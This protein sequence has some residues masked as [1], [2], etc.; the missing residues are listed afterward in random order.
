LQ[1]AL[2]CRNKETTKNMVIN[3]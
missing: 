2:Q 1:S 3:L